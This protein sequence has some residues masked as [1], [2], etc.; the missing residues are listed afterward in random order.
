MRDLFVF[1]ST[2]PICKNCRRAESVVEECISG[3]EEEFNYRK[4]PLDSDEARVLGV[5][6]TPTIALEGK[7][8]V[9]GE[10]PEKQRL[11]EAFFA[12]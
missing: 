5:L 4:L 12:R 11:K 3:H 7:I 1:G 9:M 6:C 8:L 2:K 10:V